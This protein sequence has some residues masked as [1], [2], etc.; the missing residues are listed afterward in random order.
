MQTVT[1]NFE[2]FFN[3]RKLFSIA[4]L[5]LTFSFTKA[6]LNL[7]TNRYV[8]FRD[9]D[10]WP[11]LFKSEPKFIR[12]TTNE[13]FQIEQLL[14][15]AISHTNAEGKRHNDSLRRTKYYDSLKGFSRFFIGSW[16][17]ISNL[18]KYK[19]QIIIGINHWGDKEV[20]LNCFKPGPN[21]GRDADA[22]ALQKK[23]RREIISV[24]G[25]GSDYFNIRINLTQNEYYDL[26]I[27]GPL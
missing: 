10:V 6:Q 27:N 5:T 3:V 15:K 12:L 19:R 17:P 9:G 25:G 11:E 8:I 20:W 7:D 24:D 22:F 2:N 4:F 13:L 26:R 1:R 23:W 21:Q 18:S 16:K 14:K